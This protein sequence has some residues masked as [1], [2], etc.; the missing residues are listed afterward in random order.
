MHR[1]IESGFESDLPPALLG[2]PGKQL[3]EGGRHWEQDHAL[4]EDNT[5]SSLGLWVNFHV[6][7][8]MWLVSTL[9]I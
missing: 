7:F 2:L 4:I 5:S 8:L 3:S 1:R 6:I 9:K